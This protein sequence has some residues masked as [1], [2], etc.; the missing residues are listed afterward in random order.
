MHSEG[1]LLPVLTYPLKMKRTTIID[2][3][4]EF[5]QV[6]LSLMKTST[7]IDENAGARPV[8]AWVM[9]P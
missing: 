9:T 3:D 2:R 1:G 5:L 7:L 4:Q 6:R 8:G